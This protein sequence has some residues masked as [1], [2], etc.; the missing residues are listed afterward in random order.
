MFEADKALGG[1]PQG[2]VG[3]GVGVGSAFKLHRLVHTEK[4]RH[5]DFLWQQMRQL[6]N[7]G[8]VLEQ[9]HGKA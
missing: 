8:K 1:T 3:G 7:I 4:L 6:T 2:Y 9:Q 5:L